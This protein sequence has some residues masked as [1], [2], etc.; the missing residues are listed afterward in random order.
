M[1]GAGGWIAQAA[2][3]PIKDGL[4]CLVT[5]SGG[6]RWVIPKGLIDPGMS[7]AEAALQEAWEEAGLVGLLEP[8]PI[9]TYCYE[10]WDSTCRVT[11]FLM[12]V[13]RVAEDWPEQGMRRRSWVR[14]DRA[15]ELVENPDLRKVLRRTLLTD[16]DQKQ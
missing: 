13:T 6:R 14:P 7:A 8:D 2:T 5:S 3:L 10:K 12:R 16:G 4:V 15:V 11:V 9:G 1:S